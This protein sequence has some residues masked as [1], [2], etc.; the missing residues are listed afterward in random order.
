MTNYA[1]W[2]KFN[3]DEELYQIDARGK[4]E[5]FKN[6]I[7]KENQTKLNLSKDIQTNSLQ[8]SESIHSK[9]AVE[10]LKQTKYK[11][12]KDK[13][14]QNDGENASIMQSKNDLTF[15]SQVA[16]TL[17]NFSL[18]LSNIIKDVEL[19]QLSIED[20][21]LGVD[22][23]TLG[24]KSIQQ[25]EKM[26]AMKNQLVLFRNEHLNNTEIVKSL[27]II[28]DLEQ[29]LQVLFHQLADS[30]S[31]S[32]LNSGRYAWASEL[33]RF[34]LKR[35]ELQAGPPKAAASPWLV[36]GLAFLAM[37]SPYLAGI[38]CR[39]A[40]A[41]SPLHPSA[42]RVMEFV[43]AAELHWVRARETPPAAAMRELVAGLRRGGLRLVAE[44]GAGS[45][46]WLRPEEIP[47][48]RTDLAAISDGYLVSLLDGL[49]PPESTVGPSL[50]M[51][52]SEASVQPVVL[53]PDDL[54]QAVAAAGDSAAEVVRAVATELFYAA[55]ALSLEGM[56]RAAAA[57]YLAAAL[58]DESGGP[59]RGLQAAALANLAHCTAI[60][61]PVGM[62]RSRALPS[63]R[64]TLDC[65]LLCPAALYDLAIA[66]SVSPLDRLILR[67]HKADV[68]GKLH[69]LSEALAELLEIQAELLTNPSLARD[70]SCSFVIFRS[71]TALFAHLY[72]TG[73]KTPFCGE[74]GDTAS[75]LVQLQADVASQI[76]KL[77]FRTGPVDA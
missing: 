58:L 1:R 39:Q 66:R 53:H 31:I 20:K 30:L 28:D 5:E 21:V 46:V 2:D 10:A 59:R 49:W 24:L 56:Q 68:L 77:R 29:N 65:A 22:C 42:S 54:S 7:T 4:L 51:D 8:I 13:N 34:S 52:D 15:Y 63:G 27:K 17:G 61:P 18:N 41:L 11:R 70:S 60:A 9:I 62:H 38:H 55:Q 6:E 43:D 37:G 47:V 35:H 40:L 72:I 48:L 45:G 36:R 23:Y 71:Q 19:M 33:S 67:Y 32:S 25:L 73:Q 26:F 16:E 69:R 12:R 14:I 3:S 57:K 76:T 75:L 64:L 50:H 74:D 44:D